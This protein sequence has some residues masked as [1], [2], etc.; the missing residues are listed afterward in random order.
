MYDAPAASR[1]STIHRDSHVRPVLS[2]RVLVV[3][4]IQRRHEA[5]LVSAEFAL[6]DSNVLPRMV[7]LV[8]RRDAPEVIALIPECLCLAHDLEMQKVGRHDVSMH[9]K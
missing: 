5:Q 4:V 2:V 1:E 3:H 9:D 8:R 6:E 7:R